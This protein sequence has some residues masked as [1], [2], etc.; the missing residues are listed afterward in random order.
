MKR[1]QV[2]HSKGNFVKF[3]LR[4]VRVRILQR[5]SILMFIFLR[6]F[7]MSNFFSTMSDINNANLEQLEQNEEAHFVRQYFAVTNNTDARKGCSKN[8]VCNALCM[9]CDK[10]FS[11]CSTSRADNVFL[12]WELSFIFNVADWSLIC[13]AF[14]DRREHE[15]S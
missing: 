3:S 13:R 12:L 14:H 2:G 7:T 15:I 6:L 1:V 4:V 10:N 11:G 8:A 5:S 9:F